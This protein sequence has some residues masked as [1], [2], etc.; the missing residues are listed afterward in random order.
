MS[1]IREC[2]LPGH[3]WEYFTT[4]VWAQFTG[5]PASFY[6]P[7]FL[8]WM[9]L[10][11]ILFGVSAGRMALAQHREASGGGGLPGPAGMETAA[12]S[13]RRAAGHDPVRAASFSHR[14]RGM[15]IRTRS[16]DGCRDFGFAAP[17]LRVRRSGP[18]WKR[19]W[20][21]RQERP[22][23]GTHKPVAMAC[24][25]RGRLLRCRC[26]PRRLASFFPW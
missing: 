14:V 18:P 11:F 23:G 2:N 10:N 13:G 20:K 22:Q 26:W 6:R 8:L 3:I 25:L 9:R 17:V 24:R 15:D 5:G 19:N 7:L 21:N 16:L 1:V 4:F 12:R